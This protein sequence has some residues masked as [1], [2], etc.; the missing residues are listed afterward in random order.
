MQR[1]GKYEGDYV[2]SCIK[3]KKEREIFADEL[4]TIPYLRVLPSQA[5]YFLCE[6][7]PPLTAQGISLDLLSK[8]DILIK[9][10]SS[11]KGFPK[12][13]Q[14]IRIAIRDRMDNERLILALK[15]INS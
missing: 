3:F 1:Y 10:C 6:V 12:G 14:Y 11:K 9:D 2:R 5:N 4:S 13:A 15:N 7:L 8:Y